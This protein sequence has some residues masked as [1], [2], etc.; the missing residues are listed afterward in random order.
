MSF[1]VTP[2]TKRKVHYSSITWNFNDPTTIEN[3]YPIPND[4]TVVS[5]TIE[6]LETPVPTAGA[7]VAFIDS[8]DG[9]ALQ[10][11]TPSTYSTNQIIELQPNAGGFF[12][13]RAS[14]N[15]EITTLGSFTQGK[16]IATVGYFKSGKYDYL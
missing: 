14:G 16:Y 15:L 7:P 10:L 5:V 12:P 4:S 2:V 3:D 11:I 1:K 6:V 13:K 9:G 8:S